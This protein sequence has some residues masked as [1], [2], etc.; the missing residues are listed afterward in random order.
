MKRKNRFILL[1]VLLVFLLSL[2]SGC[3]RATNHVDVEYSGEDYLELGSPKSNEEDTERNPELTIT[4]QMTTQ[5]MLHV[6]RLRQFVRADANT[7]ILDENT[8]KNILVVG[9]DRRAG[10]KEEM[11]SDSMMIFSIN[12]ATNQINLVSLMRDMYIPC[13]DGKDGMINLTYLNGGAQLLEQTIELNYGI[14][15]DNYIEVDFWRFMDLFDAIG[16]ISVDITPQEAVA[17]N[18]MV[19]N[20]RFAHYD[21]G[22]ETPVWTVPSGNTVLDPEQ[23]LAFC[24]MRENIGGDWART[25]RQRRVMITTYNMLNSLSYS[26]LIKMIKSCAKYFN[27]DMDVADMLGY[28]YWLKKNGITQ[29]NGYRLPLEG[30]YTQEIREGSLNVLVPQIEP[31]KNAIQQYI[32]G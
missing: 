9:Q 14:H 20:G 22:D 10:D 5:E 18:K 13:A 4:P 12:T 2:C 24:R 21:Y 29:I 6:K 31:N 28:F 27:T 32:Y 26:T 19:T 3:G 17:L 30:T 16:P 8:V 11:R 25:E 1:V 7:E 15:I 23:L